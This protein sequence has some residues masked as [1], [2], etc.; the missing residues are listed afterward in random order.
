MYMYNSVLCNNVALCAVVFRSLIA[1]RVGAS[2]IQENET[3]K[4]HGAHDHF[5]EWIV[6]KKSTSEINST[7]YQRNKATLQAQ[8]Y[9][10][11]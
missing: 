6:A 9:S 2:S 10:K 11:V 3:H 8:A 5:A 1:I 7:H 4:L